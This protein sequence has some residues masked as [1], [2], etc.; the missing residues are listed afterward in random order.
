MLTRLLKKII[1]WQNMF[2]GRFLKLLN[3]DKY[4]TKYGSTHTLEGLYKQQQ[5][6]LDYAKF[7]R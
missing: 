1:S 5:Q 6:C 2:L 7:I 3:C 4:S